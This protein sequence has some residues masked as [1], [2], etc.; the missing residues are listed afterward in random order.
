MVAESKP[1]TPK[2][3]QRY[4]ITLI[5]S[6]F[7]AGLCSIV[8]ELQIATTSSYF[9]GDSVKQFSLVIGVYMAAM[10]FGS[11]LSKFIV[12]GLVQRF[13]ISEILLGLVGGLSVPL[14][15]LAFAYTDSMQLFTLGI[16]AIVGAL[17][18]LEIPLLTRLMDEFKELRVNIANVLSLDYVGALL[19]TVSF[20]FLLLPFFGSYKTSLLLGLVN[21]TIGFVNLWCFR[22]RMTSFMYKFCMAACVTSTGILIV[23]FFAAEPFLHHWNSSVFDD[24]VVYSEQT[25]Y[26]NI[27]LTRD[28]KDVRLYLNGNLQFSSLDEYR[29][30]EALVH[31]PMMNFEGPVDVLL[32]GAGDGLAIRE[33]LKYEHVRKIVLVDLDERMV[34]LAKKNN[35]I[36][37]LNQQSLEDPKVS[38]VHED[39]FKFLLDPRNQFDLILSDLP[40]P[41]NNDLAR[42]YSN[43]FYKLISSRLKEGGVFTAQATSPYFARKAFWCIVSTIKETDRFFEV[44][45]YHVNIPSFGDWGFVMARKNTEIQRKPLKIETRYLEDQIIAELFRFSKDMAPLSVS[46][47]SLDQPKLLSYYL[48]GWTYWN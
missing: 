27:V 47:N 42:L 19:A 21:M 30:H 6:I 12:K 4:V 28:R 34:R 40:D 5:Y 13:V 11:Y 3:K 2:E 48:Q 41:N 35:Y 25:R 31:L 16:T 33:L 37:S 18:G 9:E 46:T 14:I 43:E 24:R 1:A 7:V 44:Q 8:Y 45:P 17:I 29:Y 15:Y 36:R 10:G 38:V 20:P 22:K 23:A 39:A 26:Q 32:L